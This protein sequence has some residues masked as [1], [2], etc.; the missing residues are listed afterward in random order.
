MKLFLFPGS[1]ETLRNPKNLNYWRFK[2]SSVDSVY[3]YNIKIDKKSNYT[4]EH[5]KLTL[6]FDK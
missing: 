3:I 5:K 4:Q 1:K 6:L 2:F